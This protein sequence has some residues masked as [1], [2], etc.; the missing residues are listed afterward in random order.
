MKL[1]KRLHILILSFLLIVP[2]VSIADTFT[3][4]VVPQFDI[5]TIFSIW[6]PILDVLEEKTGH[7]FVL[8]GSKDIPT[9]EKSFSKGDF[10]FAYMNPYH[11]TISDNYQPIARDHGRKLY[12][13]LVINAD[14]DIQDVQ[15]LNEKTVVFPAPNA[16][17]A[18]LMIRSELE[19]KYG[20]SFTPKYVNTHSS[21]YL[22]VGLNLASA[23]GGVQKTFNQQHADVKDNV[24]ILLKTDSVEPHPFTAKLDLNP[25]IVKKVTEALLQMGQHEEYQKLLA[26][27]PFK[28]IGD[29]TDHDYDQVRRL[30]L[31]RYYVSPK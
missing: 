10:D 7:K 29:A 9:F 24:R 27:V 28:K 22:N 21:V 12:G 20:I 23:G 17:G 19:Q 31:E 25:E 8:K 11:Y 1:T 30:N 14:G 6:Q 15:Q 2:P 26:K 4:G 18:S 5:K 13:I 16:L 3:V